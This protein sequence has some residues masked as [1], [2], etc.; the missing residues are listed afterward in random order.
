MTQTRGPAPGFRRYP[1]HTVSIRDAASRWVVSR[2]SVIL[3][4]SEQVRILEE[5][6]YGEVAYFP[7]SDVEPGALL[8]S[9]S[10]TTCP[11][12]GRAKYFRLAEG[13]DDVDVAWM[14]PKTYDEAVEIAGYIAFY[15][16]RVSIKQS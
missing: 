13:S 10:E 6:G 9:A 15:A 7:A 3:A 8:Q 1:H 14:Y 2:G 12:K 16:D 5:T 4:E 11:F